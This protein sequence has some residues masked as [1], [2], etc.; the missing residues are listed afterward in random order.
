MEI[1]SVDKVP[2]NKKKRWHEGL[3]A[4]TTK[5]KKLMASGLWIKSRRLC[6]MHC[7][8]QVVRFKQVAG[9][10]HVAAYAKARHAGS[11]TGWN[12]SDFSKNPAGPA[13]QRNACMHLRV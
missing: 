1:A 4:F 7:G 10:S 2:Q 9:L 12:D 3:M 6:A 11:H 5:G 13:A 8:N